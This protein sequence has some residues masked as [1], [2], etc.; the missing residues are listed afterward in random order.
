[1]E[2]P[3]VGQPEPGTDSRVQDRF[4]RIDPDQT[5]AAERGGAA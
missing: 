5:R 2:N 3:G 4:D 1:M